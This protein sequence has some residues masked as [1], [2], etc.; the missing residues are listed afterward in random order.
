MTL[1]G[2]VIPTARLRLRPFYDSDLDDLVRLIGDWDIARWVSSVPHPYSEAD[3]RNWIGSV[4]R[5][6]A[7]GRP[8][9]FAIALQQPDH[10]IGGIGLDGDPGDDSG[11]PALGYWVGKPYWGNHYARE[12]VAAIIDYGFET[13]GIETIRAYAD[14]DNA[15]SQKVLLHC[16][17]EKVGD[18]E[19]RRPTRNG[20]R[21]A[22]LFHI[23]RAGDG[24]SGLPP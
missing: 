11:D 4:R 23:A 17:L 18:I 15:A 5:Q 21:T 22:P 12:A 3:G 20:A 6:H 14:P 7:E 9:R 19:L 24:Q 1:S 13:L 16:G 10:L 8:R 2:I